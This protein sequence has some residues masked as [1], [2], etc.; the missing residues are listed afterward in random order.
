MKSGE[1]TVLYMIYRANRRQ[2]LNGNSIL[3]FYFGN[4]PAISKCVCQAQTGPVF[5]WSVNRII[6]WGLI[7]KTGRKG[8]ITAKIEACWD[9]KNSMRPVVVYR[10]TISVAGYI[11]KS[12]NYM[13]FVEAMRTLNMYWTLSRLP[14]ENLEAPTD[15]VFA[16]SIV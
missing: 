5:V 11:V 2:L 14:S 10:G 15:Q 16:K 13:Q 12:V 1:L 3:T 9:T 8:K 4:Y 6:P 7:I